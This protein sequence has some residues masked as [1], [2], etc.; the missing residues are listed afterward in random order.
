MDWKRGKNLGAAFHFFWGEELSA[1]LFDKS[2]WTGTNKVRKILKFCL[3]CK[4]VS[5]SQFVCPVL[6]SPVQKRCGHIGHIVICEVFIFALIFYFC[7]MMLFALNFLNFFRR[8]FWRRR[9]LSKSAFLYTYCKRV[10]ISL[11]SGL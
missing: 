4:N 8:S 2:C 1:F 5:S 7:V 6:A 3:S 11:P 9:E 10:K